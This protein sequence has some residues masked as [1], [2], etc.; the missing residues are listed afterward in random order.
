MK[1]EKNKVGGKTKKIVV[2]VVVITIIL[3]FLAPVVVFFLD[4]TGNI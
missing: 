3:S 2:W 4:S 1:T